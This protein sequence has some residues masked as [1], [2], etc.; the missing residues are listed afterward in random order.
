[1]EAV[2]HELLIER[3]IVTLRHAP[4]IVVIGDVE[5]IGAGPRAAFRV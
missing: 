3:P 2:E 1:L 4:F 5:G